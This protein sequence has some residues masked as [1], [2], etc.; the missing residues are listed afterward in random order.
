MKNISNL[1]KIN[2]LALL[3]IAV[4]A[5]CKK[6]EPTT[7]IPIEGDFSMDNSM[8]QIVSRNTDPDNDG[9]CFEIGFPVMVALPDGGEETADNMEE[10]ENIYN[11]WFE[12]N[13]ADTTCPAIVYPLSVTLEDGTTHSVATEAELIALLEDCIEVDIDLGWEDCFTIQYP[14]TVLY[15]DGTTATVGSD[16]ELGEAMYEWS[17]NHPTDTLYPTIAFPINVILADGTP[18]S[19]ADEAGINALFEECFGTWEPEEPTGIC[20]EYVFPVTVALPDGTTATANSYEELDQV[21]T[22]WF[23]AHPENPSEFPTIAYPMNLQLENGE[24]VTVNNDDEF[25]AIIDDCY[26]GEGGGFEDC[27]TFNYPLTLV[28]PDGSTPAI[29]NDEEL[30]TAIFD[31]YENNPNSEEDPSFQYPIS[32]TLTA[33]GSV[34]SVNNDDEL[35][36]IFEE[37]YDCVVN[38]GEGLV[39]GGKHSVAAKVAVKQHAKVQNQVKQKM[40]KV[41]TQKARR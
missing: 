33:D 28:L 7:P 19:V 1:L 35:N 14:V 32:V 18:V 22:A 31:F 10:L 36:A 34:V 17:E 4:F 23:E 37:C 40:A 25:Y 8:N 6:D 21:F 16:Q 12:N 26:G 39:L 29:N 13:P 3:F 5:A 2:M 24:L 27:F 38:G 30:W 41:M 15:P 20:F 9:L 11:E